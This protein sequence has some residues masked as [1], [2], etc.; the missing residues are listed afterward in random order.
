VVDDPQ[1]ALKLAGLNKSIETEAESLSAASVLNVLNSFRVDDLNRP[2]MTF[3]EIKRELLQQEEEERIQVLTDLFG[4]C[5]TTDAQKSKLRTTEDSSCVKSAVHMMRQEI[6]LIPG[7][8]KGALL[9]AKLKCR[10]D[11]F[12]DARLEKFLR[13]ADWDPKVCCCCLFM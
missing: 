7:D 9:D 6:D 8:N 13:R 4:K 2:K 11:E 1:N 3:A 10:P 5:M 12:S